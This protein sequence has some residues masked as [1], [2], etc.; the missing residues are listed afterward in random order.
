MQWSQYCK[1]VLYVRMLEMCTFYNAN[2]NNAILFLIKLLKLFLI[3]RYLRLGSNSNN[4]SL[5]ASGHFD[6]YVLKRLKICR[7]MIWF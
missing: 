2:E 7:M 5:R 1:S 3:Y 4:Y 6:W